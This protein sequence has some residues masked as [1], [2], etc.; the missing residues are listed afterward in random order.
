MREDVQIGRFEAGLMRA[1]DAVEGL[2][3]QHF[4]AAHESQAS[5][6]ELSNR[7]YLR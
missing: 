7:P 3:V 5:P 6:D 2:L 1:I 4:A